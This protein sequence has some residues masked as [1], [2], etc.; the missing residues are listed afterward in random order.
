MKKILAAIA[1]LTFFA[2]C[3]KEVSVDLSS[4]SGSP[5]GSGLLVKSVAVIGSETQTTVYGYDAQKRLE[6]MTITGTA[7]G[8]S[9]NSFH[10][11]VRDNA[12]RIV[13]VLQKAPDM[14]GTTTD[15]ATT[16]YHYPNATTMDFDYSIYVITMN[17]GG[18]SM[19]TI[20][21]AVYNYSGGKMTSYD[22]F[23]FSSVM[24]GMVMMNSKCEFA[25]DASNRVNDMKMYTDVNNP[26]G[27]ME[28]DIEWKYTYSASSVYYVY[29]S[30]HGAQN[31]ALNGLPNT[32]AN[33]ISKMEASSNTTSPP[34]NTVITTSY[35]NGT[36]NK[37]KSGTV[38]NV[39]SGQ[40]TQTIN[41][42]FFY[43]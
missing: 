33:F 34:T 23:M 9:V 26:G 31:F 3:Q 21:S 36:G 11:Y 32:T 39:T 25:Y 19:S 14:M 35:V 7:G 10:K 37:P 28:L 22:K 18:I 1:A 16:T 12:G 13:K 6:T 5:T 2:S 8:M 40:P 20:D 29:A 24:P 30:A 15:T 4:D 38:V 43:Q 27:P 42:T 41:Y 17:M